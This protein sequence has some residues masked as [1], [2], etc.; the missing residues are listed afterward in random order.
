MREID[1]RGDLGQYIAS[2]DKR[3]QY[4]LDALDEASFDFMDVLEL[5]WVESRAVAGLGRQEVAALVDY[6]H[7]LDRQIRDAARHQVNDRTD[8]PG[9]EAAARMQAEKHRCTG[10]LLLAHKNRWFG[11]CQVH[12][13]AAHCRER[14][15]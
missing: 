8:L 6:R 9:I 1:I 4:R 3:I 5:A 14:L 11:K 13:R 7:V 10:L 15:D 2:P 12:P